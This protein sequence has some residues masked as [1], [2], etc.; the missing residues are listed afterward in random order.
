[1]SFKHIL[2]VTAACVALAGL[3]ACGGDEAE[4]SQAP[5]ATAGGVECVE[6][7]PGQYYWDGSRFAVMGQ[8]AP[9]SRPEPAPVPVRETT[10]WA[11][12]LERS[13]PELGF[14]WMGLRVRGRVATLTG[15]APD[16]NAKERGLAA[17]EAAI[18][19]YEGGGQDISLIVDGIAVEGGARGVGESLAALSDGEA[20]LQ[21]CQRAFNETMQGRNVQFETR[22]DTISPSSARLLDAVS[23]VAI[24]CQDY[25]IEI[26]GHTDSRGSDDYNRNLSQQRADAVRTYL[27]G[28]GVNPDALEAVGFGE[29]KPIDTAETADAWAKNRRTEFTVTERR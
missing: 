5:A 17:G 20:T 14:P 23:G 25:S 27:V 12:E 3:T 13:F 1:M 6:L 15:I 18:A 8:P 10:G 29:S 21:A 16:V 9:V 11:S 26:G 4:T 28:K 24:L 22:A 7:V 2:A 19:A